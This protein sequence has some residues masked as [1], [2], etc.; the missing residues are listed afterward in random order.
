MLLDSPRAHS[1][2]GIACLCG[3][4]ALPVDLAQRM[5]DLQGPLWNLYGPTET[6]IWSAAHRLH[7]ALP[8]VGRPIANTGLFILNAGLTPC[9]QGVSGE[10]LIGGVGLARGYHGQPALTAALAEAGFE[11][12]RLGPRIL[13][14]ETAGLAALAALQAL[15]GDV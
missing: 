11:G 15:H 8:F 3:G 2:R 14:T 13:R 12:L 9:P 7:Q 6:T 4:E 10:L 5:L 1:L